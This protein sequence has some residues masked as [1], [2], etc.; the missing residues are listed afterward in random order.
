MLHLYVQQTRYVFLDQ[1]VAKDKKK[2]KRTIASFFGAWLVLFYPTE[3]FSI[4]R[5]V[6]ASNQYFN[7]KGG[8]WR[9]SL[10]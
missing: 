7:R 5:N 4:F 8:E 2:I 3:M 10:I 9:V 6:K 1:M